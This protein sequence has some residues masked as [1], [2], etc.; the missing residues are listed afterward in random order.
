MK[1]HEFQAKKIFS[2][3]GIPVPAGSVAR[4]PE[5][6]RAAA[7]TFGGPVVVKVQVHA[8]GRGKAGGIRLARD[9]QEAFLIAR[10]LLGKKLVTHQ[11]NPDGTL[12]RQ[13]LVEQG[14]D[15]AKELYVGMVIDRSL[16]LPV[17]M[18]SEA[19]GMAIEEV[20]LTCTAR[21]H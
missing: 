5:E 6:A 2:D 19:G 17:I 10:D 15:I 12:V 14:V 1:I 20:T 11:T 4:T 7:A 18:A 9:S 16:C 21:P 3:Y 8:G 13:V